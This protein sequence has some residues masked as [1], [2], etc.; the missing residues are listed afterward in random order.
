M[1]VGDTRRE[2]SDSVL[3]AADGRVADAGLLTAPASDAPLTVALR[4]LKSNASTFSLTS[5]DF[6]YCRVTDQYADDRGETRIY[7]Q[8][9]Y[10]GLPVADALANISISAQGQVINAAVSFVP[11][12]SSSQNSGVAEP[13]IGATDAFSEF[14]QVYQLPLSGEPVVL[15]V[16]GGTEQT[17][18]ISSAGVTQQ[19]I[20][21]GLQYAPT[22]AGVE[23]AWAFNVEMLEAGHSYDVS[24]SAVDGEMLRVTDRV[25]RAA[26]YNVLAPPTR[27]PMKAQEP[28]WWTRAIV[29]RLPTGGTTSMAAWADFFDTRG[30]NTFVQED[31]DGLEVARNPNVGG[32]VAIGNRPSGGVNLTFD[33]PLDLTQQPISYQ[34]ASLTNLFYW[35]NYAHDVYF[36]YGSTRQPATSR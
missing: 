27:A 8:Q 35:V 22:P 13:T 19:S 14:A 3:A 29:L 15:A 24:A 7:L 21:V 25:L 31:V 10:N 12:L 26:S 17:Q 6:D 9:M 34:D 18:E 4:Y 33:F 36:N 11:G 2:P 5:R 30:N 20:T 1:F 23:L 32:S 28:S 16:M